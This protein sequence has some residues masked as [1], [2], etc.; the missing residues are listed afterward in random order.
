MHIH[1]ILYRVFKYYQFIHFSCLRV[2]TKINRF[3][4]LAGLV[5]GKKRRHKRK[6]KYDI[7]MADMSSSQ[8]PQ[9]QGGVVNQ[10]NIMYQ[11]VQGQVVYQNPQHQ[12][13]P[14]EPVKVDPTVTVTIDDV[15]VN[16]TAQ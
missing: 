12:A 4:R 1:T 7:G 3:K 5:D 8:A 16:P 13:P 10:P 14:I 15:V 9:N 2:H 6:G 11:P